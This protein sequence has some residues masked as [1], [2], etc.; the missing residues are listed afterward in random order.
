MKNL[1]IGVKIT[2]GFSAVLL[3]VIILSVAV[4]VTGQ[5]TNARLNAVDELS[6]FQDDANSFL[7]YFYDAR[8]GAN[9]LT[10]GYDQ[11]EY[12][13]VISNI[14]LANTILNKLSASAA[15]SADLSGQQ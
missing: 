14:D 4:F 12:N 5:I 6:G 7:R 13:R 15:S 8:I 1:K 9:A 3:C 2:I 11:N 10:K